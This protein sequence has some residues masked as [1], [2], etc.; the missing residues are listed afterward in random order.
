[1]GRIIL[2]A[3]S[4]VETCDWELWLRELRRGDVGDWPGKRSRICTQTC[5]RQVDTHKHSSSSTSTSTSSPTTNR[6]LPLHPPAV[7]MVFILGVNIPEHHMLKVHTPMSLCA[8][9][10]TDTP[11]ES[12]AE[13]LRNRPRRV[14]QDLRVAVDP[15]DCAGRL[16]AHGQDQLPRRRAQRNDDRERPAPEAA[17]RHQAA[18]RHGILPGET[19]CAGTETVGG[20][21]RRWR[22]C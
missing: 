10:Q 9:V 20:G 16:A 7:T 13:L 18:E 1:M 21:W 4:G 5:A 11:A 14:V 2:R 3:A 12:A 15:P 22:W 8:A 19:T 6:P 17:R